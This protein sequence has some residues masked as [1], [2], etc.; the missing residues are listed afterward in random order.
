VS[1]FCSHTF[2]KIENNFIFEQV[3]KKLEPTG[4]ELKYFLSKKLLLSSQKHGVGIRDPEKHISDPDP[5]V[6]KTPDP[7]PQHCL[8]YIKN[9]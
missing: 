6:K 4:Q 7:N 5:G 1:P 2:H 3:Q 8:G 9:P